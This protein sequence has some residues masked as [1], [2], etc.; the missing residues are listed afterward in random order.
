M[1]ITKLSVTNL[2]SDT[3]DL[4][5]NVAILLKAKTRVEIPV[6]ATKLVPTGVTIECDSP[7]ILLRAF[8]PG[9]VGAELLNT[10]ELSPNFK[11][12][13]VAVV[14]NSGQS[15][16]VIGRGHSVATLSFPA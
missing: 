13:I 1:A 14:Y 2:A 4:I 10:P 8:G 15:P 12:K 11:G 6:G 7:G 9:I 3:T 16:L 5:G